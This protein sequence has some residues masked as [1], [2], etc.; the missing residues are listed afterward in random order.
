MDSTLIGAARRGRLGLVGVAERV[1]LLGG[2]F[3]VR[4]TPGT[5][6]RLELTL[7]RWT[8]STELPGHDG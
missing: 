1:R 5:G 8:G 6:T 2:S 3:D 7:P 4:S